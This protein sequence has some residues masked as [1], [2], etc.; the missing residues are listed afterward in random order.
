MGKGNLV[1][2]KTMM[3][4]VPF[5]NYGFR[6][7]VDAALAQSLAPSMR[8]IVCTRTSDDE[9]I[10]DSASFNVEGTMV[11]NVSFFSSLSK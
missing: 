4:T 9:L 10:C 2:S 1:S 6:V 5:T 7:D 11:N 8:I 3:E